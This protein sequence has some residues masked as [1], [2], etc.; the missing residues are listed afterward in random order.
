M[1]LVALRQGAQV[2][3]QLGPVEH[4]GGHHLVVPIPA[5]VSRRKRRVERVKQ[6]ARRPCRG[7]NRRGSRTRRGTLNGSLKP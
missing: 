3:L 2:P 4:S 5:R 7:S 1:Q 6:D